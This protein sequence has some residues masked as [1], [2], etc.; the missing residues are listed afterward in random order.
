MVERAS[1]GPVTAFHMEGT[2]TDQ[3]DNLTYHRQ[4]ADQEKAIA[5]A[6]TEPWIKRAHEQLAQLHLERMECTWR[7][8][9]GAARLRQPAAISRW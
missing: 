1:D 9:D 4:R 3:D 5:D 6:A 8:G 7:T 2:M